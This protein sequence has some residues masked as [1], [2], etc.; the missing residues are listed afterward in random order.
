MIA[1]HKKQIDKFRDVAVGLECD[2]N[3]KSFDDKLRQI[4]TH[5]PKKEEAPDE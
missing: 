5:K 3:E 2:K 4:T 1:E